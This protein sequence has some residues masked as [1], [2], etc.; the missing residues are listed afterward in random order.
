MKHFRFMAFASNTD[1][2]FKD[3]AGHDGVNFRAAARGAGRFAEPVIVCRRA[4]A[5]QYTLRIRGEAPAAIRIE[6]GRSRSGECD[7][8]YKTKKQHYFL[9][10]PTSW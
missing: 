8:D 3:N 9:H 2:L 5:Q 4:A 1:L 10:V 6:S 7:A